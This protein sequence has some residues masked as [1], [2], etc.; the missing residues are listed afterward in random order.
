MNFKEGETI[1]LYSI[2]D[3]CDNEELYLSKVQAEAVLRFYTKE[4]PD[5]YFCIRER[6]TEPY[7]ANV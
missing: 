5:A 6:T 7:Q 1:T 2:K 4:Y 3:N